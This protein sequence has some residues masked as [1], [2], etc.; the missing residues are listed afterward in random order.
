[1]NL[2]GFASGDPINFSDPFGLCPKSAG[3]D[4]KSDS[5]SDCPPGS[6]GWYANRLSTG[7]GSRFWNNV[8]GALT[9]CGETEECI[10]A[11]AGAWGGGGGRSL[12]LSTR[13]VTSLNQMRMQVT[14][15]QA[16]STVKAVNRGLV[17]GEQDHIHFKDGS[18][19]NRDGSWKHGGRELTRA[20]RE[21]AELGGFKAPQP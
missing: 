18:A 10:G 12:G 6:S 21:W 1:M 14:R 9:A 3:G 16:P 19:L 7:E 15:G 11:I 13:R 4:G 2:H 20:E 5:F 17:K 8:G